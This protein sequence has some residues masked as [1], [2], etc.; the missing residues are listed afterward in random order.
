METQIGEA[1]GR[2]WQYLAAHGAVTLPQLQRGTT[3]SERLSE[4]RL[5]TPLMR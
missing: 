1:A 5:V 4:G 2:M 3:L